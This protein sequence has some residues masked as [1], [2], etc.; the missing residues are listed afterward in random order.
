MFT[1]VVIGADGTVSVWG[2]F[3]TQDKADALA[4]MFREEEGVNADGYEIQTQS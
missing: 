4:S 1:T 3:R 2:L